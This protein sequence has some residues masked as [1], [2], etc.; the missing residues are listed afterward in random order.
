MSTTSV[1][2]AERLGAV[3][4]LTS[5]PLRGKN[6]YIRDWKELNRLISGEETSPRMMEYCV[7]LAVDEWNTT[8][9]L[10]AQGVSNF[11]SRTLLLRLTIIQVLISV[12]ILK[13][14]NR[15]IYNDGGFSAQTET[16]D[17]A[18][19]RMIQL[20]RSQVE[21]KMQRLKVA[22][23]IAGGWDAGVGSEYGWIHGWYGLT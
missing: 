3:E 1:T 15:F 5:L 12:S 22:L 11:P 9:P 17:E 20:L 18:Y 7:H 13:S 19:I 10:S 6:P 23:N 14:R 21:P 4:E 8:P 2:S 16:Q